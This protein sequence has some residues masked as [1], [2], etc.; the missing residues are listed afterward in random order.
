V[1]SNV[2]VDIMTRKT[3]E[4]LRDIFSGKLESTEAAEP[5]I[6]LAAT[7]DEPLPEFVPQ[8]SSPSES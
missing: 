6:A 1:L 3:V 8:E 2:M 4:R 7:T 5:E